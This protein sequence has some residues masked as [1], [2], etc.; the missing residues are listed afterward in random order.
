MGKAGVASPCFHF[1]RY[2]LPWQG[3]CEPTLEVFWMEKKREEKYLVE[4][5]EAKTLEMYWK[6]SGGSVDREVV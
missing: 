5:K 1:A 6:P 2:P 4:K 3:N